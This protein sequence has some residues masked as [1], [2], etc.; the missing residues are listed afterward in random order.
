MPSAPWSNFGTNLM[1]LSIIVFMI[2]LASSSVIAGRSSSELL[3]NKLENNLSS[4]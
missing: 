4:R 2:S 1:I 3:L